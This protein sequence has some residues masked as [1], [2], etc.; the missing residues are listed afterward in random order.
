M[1]LQTPSVIRFPRCLLLADLTL[2]QPRPLPLCL[3]LVRD[4]GCNLE[5]G[6]LHNLH[7][8]DLNQDLRYQLG[9]LLLLRGHRLRDFYRGHFRILRPQAPDL[10]KAALF[11][12]FLM[13][14]ETIGTRRLTST[15]T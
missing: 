6:S 12:S 2:P 5:D 13:L 4:R 15:P 8:A 9:L 11:R 7:R 1:N 3:S 14:P 10:G